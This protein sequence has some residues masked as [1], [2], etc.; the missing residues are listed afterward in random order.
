[1]GM[2]SLSGEKVLYGTDMPDFVCTQFCKCCLCAV[3]C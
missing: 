1:M 2:N 3:T